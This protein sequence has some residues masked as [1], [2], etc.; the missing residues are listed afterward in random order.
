MPLRRH[1]FLLRQKLSVH[2]FEEGKE[3]EKQ[4][5]QEEE[6]RR[7]RRRKRRRRRRRKEKKK[8]YSKHK[9]EMKGH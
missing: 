9:S 8:S 1:K 2:R 5:E 3:E 7:R 6:R 4:E